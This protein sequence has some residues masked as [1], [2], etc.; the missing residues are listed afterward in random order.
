MGLGGYLAWTAVAR[1]IRK[2][3][4]NN[5][6]LMPVEQ[7]GSFFKFIE[8]DINIFDRNNDFCT[9]YKQ[10]AINSDWRILP[11][12]L[13]NP[14]A[15]YCKKDTPEKAFHRTDKHI[16]E[17]SCEIYDIHNPELRCYLKP[18]AS[19][20]WFKERIEE[21]FGISRNEDLPAFITIEPNSKTNYTPNRAYPFK[22]WQNIVNALK[23]KISFVQVGVKGSR[24]LENVIDWTGKT[25]FKNTAAMIGYSK[26][27]LSAE[28]G[29]VHAAT[30]FDTKS[31]VIITG[32]QAKKM[33]AYP[34]NINVNIAS[35]GPCGLK[36]ECQECKKDAENHNW[37]NIVSLIEDELCL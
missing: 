22:K 7:Y 18:N 34:Q 21:W 19:D 10:G 5:I 33:V 25:S 24:V 20:W 13:N 30:A 16:I 15:N 28:G 32:Y 31:L 4:G 23:D 26:L 35:H 8:E 11:L 27:F 12:A 17:Q 1:E 36:I 6:R 9:N 37:E 14:N 2:K 29:L 3:Y